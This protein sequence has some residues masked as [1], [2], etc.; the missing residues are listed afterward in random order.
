MQPPLS[1]EKPKKSTS[2]TSTAAS[3]AHA[4]SE[5]A[6]G[7][8]PLH[9]LDARRIQTAPALLT[10]NDVL[11]L[12]RSIGNRATAQLSPPDAKA[13]HERAPANHPSNAQ[14]SKTQLPPSSIE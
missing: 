11:T 7:L 4:T 10:S 2:P 5:L 3:A 14:P 12:Q 1:S 9:T 8:Y 6:A 13:G